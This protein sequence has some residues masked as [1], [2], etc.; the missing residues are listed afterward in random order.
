MKVASQELIETATQDSKLQI[1]NSF[2][3]FLN[4]NKHKAY[5]NTVL[6][7]GF[8]YLSDRQKGT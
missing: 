2:T 6:N 3:L 7:L 8:I 1:K 4:Q 5:R